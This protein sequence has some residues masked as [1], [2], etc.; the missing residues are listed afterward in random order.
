MI[1]VFIEYK[2]DEQKRSDFF[3]RMGSMRDEIGKR[4]GKQYR[5]LEGVEQPNLI[6]EAFEVETMETYEAIKAWRLADETFSQCVAGGA[7]KLHIWA[8][9]RLAID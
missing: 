7:A 2:L 9:A 3:R 5:C 8:F 6:V 1:T 4:G